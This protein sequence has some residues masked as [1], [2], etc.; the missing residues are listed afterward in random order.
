MAGRRAIRLRIWLETRKAD[1][2]ERN[3]FE[4]R[5]GPHILTRLRFELTQH[6]WEWFQLHEKIDLLEGNLGRCHSIVW[7]FHTNQVMR[8]AP[9]LAEYTG[10]CVSISVITR[11][12][13]TWRRNQ[14]S[15][16]PGH[17]RIMEDR[18]AWLLDTAASRNNR[19]GRMVNAASPNDR[20]GQIVNAASPKNRLGQMVATV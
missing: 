8:M 15:T 4:N 3:V 1:I 20:L 5:L 10:C 13:G 6:P 14:M 17:G 2:P 7:L 18:V 19:L 9:V 16:L 11:I 12:R